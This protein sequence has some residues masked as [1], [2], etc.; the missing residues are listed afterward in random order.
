M[1]LRMAEGRS[2]PAFAYNFCMKLLRSRGKQVV[3]FTTPSGVMGTVATSIPADGFA[4]WAKSLEDRLLELDKI[5][6]RRQHRSKR[7]AK[8]K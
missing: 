6:A 8:K 2:P 7:P 3:Q 5:E 1:Q 4:G